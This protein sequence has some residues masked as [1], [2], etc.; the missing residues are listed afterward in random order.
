MSVRNWEL[1]NVTGDKGSV[2]SLLNETKQLRN[3][4]IHIQSKNYS[5]SIFNDIESSLNRLLKSA[6][7][8]YQVP[9]GEYLQHQ[10][11]LDNLFNGIKKTTIKNQ[12]KILYLKQILTRYAREERLE[13]WRKNCANV[14]LPFSKSLFKRVSIYHDIKLSFVRQVYGSHLKDLV[15]FPASD[16]L[17]STDKKLKIVQG[18]PGSGKTTFVK[19]LMEN[20]LDKTESN[21]NI[22]GLEEYDLVIMCE[23]RTNQ[24]TGLADLVKMNFPTTLTA[25][26]EKDIFEVLDKLRVLVIIDGYDEKNTNSDSLLAEIMECITR[27]SKFS[28]IVTTRPFAGCGLQAKLAEKKIDFDNITVEGIRHTEEQINFIRNYTNTLEGNRNSSVILKTFQKLNEEVQQIL[29][30]P[31][32]LALFCC[33]CPENVDSV[34]RWTTER[35]IFESLLQFIKTKMRHRMK[36]YRYIED[37]LANSF[38]DNIIKEIGK[39]CLKLICGKNYFMSENEYKSFCGEC[40]S[41][42]NKDLDYVNILSAVFSPESS[43]F[44]D[45]QTTYH[46]FHS[47]LQE[48]FACKY[49]C[50]EL[51]NAQ[52]MDCGKISWII[53]QVNGEVLSS[54][55]LTR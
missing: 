48:Y 26:S 43:G 49:I 22:S 50:E 6:S 1:T 37:S 51:P 24:S 28:V 47:S 5:T 17:S 9:L 16:I 10:K 41:K 53:T 27:M 2:K 38:V 18:V 33:L 7:E 45:D 21:M 23:C 55:S 35:H 32:L 34:E 19:T 14:R 20:W 42:I 40:N 30:Y 46:L 3:D 29:S 52:E 12:S 39:T 36:D 54:S 25:I 44:N 8:L 13:V 15:T 31:I 4:V 11:N